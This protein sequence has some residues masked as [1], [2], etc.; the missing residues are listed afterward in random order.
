[1]EIK[2]GDRVRIREWKDMEKEFGLNYTG[3]IHCAGLFTS[4]MKH[5][6]G[7]EIKVTSV[8]KGIKANSIFIQDL[9]RYKI[10]SDMLEKIEPRNM[11]IK[12]IINGTTTVALV[13][14][15][16]SNVYKKGIAKL[17]HKDSYNRQMG[18]KVALYKALGIYGD[19][20]TLANFSN[21]ELLQVLEERL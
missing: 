15:E 21:K 11:D 3:N 19:E 12:I 5:L 10:S 7:Q 17:F 2:V 20:K 18:I 4:N 8:R 14:M 6:C 13:K 1:M 9:G 16:G